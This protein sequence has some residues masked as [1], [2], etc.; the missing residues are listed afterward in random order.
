MEASLERRRLNRIASFL[1]RDALLHRTGPLELICNPE[2]WRRDYGD[3][4]LFC[5]GGSSTVKAVSH[6]RYLRKQAAHGEDVAF[7]S[8]NPL[9]PDLMQL[10]VP[11]A[12]SLYL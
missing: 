11:A 8:P 9:C 3:G 6:F 7:A 10:G 12:G 5:G 4:V 2:V 1:S